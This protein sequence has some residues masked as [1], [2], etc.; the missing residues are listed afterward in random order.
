MPVR[1]EGVR[2]PCAAILDILIDPD[3]GIVE[4]FFVEIGLLLGT[5]VLFLSTNDVRRFGTT[6]EIAHREV[7]GPLTE[8]IRLQE[9]SD[10]CRP[11]LSQRIVTE[12]GRFIGRCRD[13]QFETKTFRLEWLFPR[14]WLRWGVA[15]P[16]HDV[17]RIGREAIVVRDAVAPK[18]VEVSAEASMTL[19]QLTSEPAT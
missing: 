6:V 8:R 17:V 3:R 7:L 1:E 19:P 5:E 9:I 4:G 14:K 10:S 11:V 13:V 2:E 12:S 15:L 18:P 16:I